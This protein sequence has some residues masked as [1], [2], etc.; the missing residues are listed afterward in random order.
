MKKLFLILLLVTTFSH[1]TG[2]EWDEEKLKQDST[3]LREAR[4]IDDS[5]Y[6][7]FTK[8]VYVDYELT[9][10]CGCAIEDDAGWCACYGKQTQMQS[11]YELKRWKDGNVE[12]EMWIF[13]FCGDPDSV[14]QIGSWEIGGQY[15]TIVPDN[16][17]LGKKIKDFKHRLNKLN[18][19]MKY[20]PCSKP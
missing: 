17:E 10:L 1:A 5:L 7:R 6:A 3:L 20:S 12:N 14:V 11:K 18:A 4:E 19:K 16:S 2:V 9:G 8:G 15:H 13:N